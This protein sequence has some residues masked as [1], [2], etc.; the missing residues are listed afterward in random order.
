MRVKY[1]QTSR[2]VMTNGKLGGSRFWKYGSKEIWKGI[3]RYFIE[4]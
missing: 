1:V 2:F 3:S 4:F